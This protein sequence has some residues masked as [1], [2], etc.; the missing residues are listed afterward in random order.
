MYLPVKITDGIPTVWRSIKTV[1]RPEQGRVSLESMPEMRDGMHKKR[2]LIMILSMLCVMYLLTGCGMVR[3]IAHIRQNGTEAENVEDTADEED[4]EPG[5][6]TG[7]DS[8]TE[9]EAEDSDAAGRSAQELVKDAFTRAETV[10]L[11][12]YPV[13]VD[14]HVP[15]ILSD[16]EGAKEINRD[17]LNV[18]QDVMQQ[19]DEESFAWN[20]VGYEAYRNGDILSLLVT[21]YS[22][23]DD[24]TLHYTY[25]LNLE[26]GK[27]MDQKELIE[28]LDFETRKGESVEAAVLRHIRRE[29]AYASD[30]DMKYFFESVFFNQSETQDKQE[31]YA[32]YLLMRM[33]T[34][35]EDNI[36]LGLPMYLDGQGILQVAVPVYVM[37]GGGLYDHILS[38]MT[39]HDRADRELS[40]DQA[41]SV[42]YR[43]GR[44]TVRIDQSDWTNAA[45]GLGNLEFGKEY[46]VHGIYKD[47]TDA[48]MLPIMNG[49]YVVPVF[50]S[51][52]GMVS[53]LDLYSC[54]EAGYFCITEPVC[55]L[56]NVEAVTESSANEIAAALEQFIFEQSPDF[57]RVAMGLY[58][59]EGFS[60][61][62][63]FH[64]DGGTQYTDSYYLGFDS[65]REGRFLYQ[66]SVDD[67]GIYFGYEGKCTYL[68]MNESG[69]IF[70]CLLY[71]QTDGGSG[72][73]ISG[74]F[75]ER[76]RNDWNEK[77]MEWREWADYRLLNG[78]DLFGTEG[79]LREL[80][81]S[82]G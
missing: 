82:A 55:G 49:E 23:M 46:E 39:E 44:M 68:G 28:T 67:V 79:D 33:E 10:E 37:A 12:D 43:D 71:E 61:E 4:T 24:Y 34:L 11:M 9:P 63:T 1:V 6:E 65:E 72:E 15:E 41:V 14:Y 45:F 8:N 70:A 81:I 48:A 26:T 32:Q 80:E 74:A 50:V 31:M 27:R 69:M 66:I 36:H 19:L 17:I 75:L 18:C 7:S 38:P 77:T 25:N 58:E 29:A 35:Q 56:T 54:A 22:I 42:T 73:A 2:N 20:K 21:K 53:Y 3:S 16:S 30:L 57:S 47:Y 59:G 64:T 51:E 5:T 13:D 40:F 60:T 76:R 78:Y 62:T 52:D